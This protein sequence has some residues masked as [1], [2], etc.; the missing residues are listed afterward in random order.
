MTLTFGVDANLTIAVVGNH[1]TDVESQTGAL[2]KV[3]ELDKTDEH[4]RMVLFWNAFACIFA[5]DI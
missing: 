1:L 2:D 4:F 3:V 5:I